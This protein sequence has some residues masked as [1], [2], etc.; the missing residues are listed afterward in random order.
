MIAHNSSIKC[1]DFSSVPSRRVHHVLREDAVVVDV[2]P[3]LALL[4]RDRDGAYS[5]R[6]ATNSICGRAREKFSEN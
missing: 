6:R 3:V 5:S 4:L 1:G 2:V